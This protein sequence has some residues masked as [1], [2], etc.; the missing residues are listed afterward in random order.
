MIDIELLI[1]IAVVSVPLLIAARWLVRR[2]GC[3]CHQCGNRM[4]FFR[5]LTPEEQKEILQYFRIHENRDPDTSA[6][7]LCD[8]CLIVYDDFSGEKKSMSGD[9][10]SL[11]KV[12]NSPYVNYLGHAVRTGAV[13]GFREA[14]S[15][16]IEEVECLR[17]ER[18]PSGYGSCVFC[19]TAIKPT[20][21]YD[22]HTLYI[23]RQ[24]APSKYKFLVPL[25]DKAI[26]KRC[27][28]VWGN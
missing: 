5:E 27:I 16:Y 3:D 8:H 10:R 13:A 12:C 21:C 14:N 7:F 24:V 9:N 25:T 2:V 18:K 1:I 17:C 19:D 28:D 15:K 6:I 4:S 11:C 20:V 22:C 26:L 23:W